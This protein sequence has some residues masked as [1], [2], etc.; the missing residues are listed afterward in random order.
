MFQTSTTTIEVRIGLQTRLYHSFITTAPAVLD[1]PSTLTLYAGPL[2]DIASLALEDLPAD[3]AAADIPSRL[4]LIDTT[5]LLWQRDRCSA[6]GYRLTPADSVVVGTTLRLWL[7]HRLL[8]PARRTS[9]DRRGTIGSPNAANNAQPL[10]AYRRVARVRG[11]GEGLHERRTRSAGRR[12]SPVRSLDRERQPTDFRTHRN[13][14]SV[15]GRRF[16]HRVVARVL[17]PLGGRSHCRGGRLQHCRGN[18]ERLH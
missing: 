15:A 11:C 6:Q 9:V 17:R 8:S 12:R 7:L 1:A 3:V 4:V 5:E 13:A 18:G 14:A 16:A 10:T 2:K